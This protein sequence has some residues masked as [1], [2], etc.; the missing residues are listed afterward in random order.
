LHLKFNRILHNVIRLS[1]L[2]VFSNLISTAEIFHPLFI[3]SKVVIVG[4]VVSSWDSGLISSWDTTLR[5][6]YYQNVMHYMFFFYKH[7]K[8][9]NQAWLCLT[10]FDFEAHSMLSL[11]LTFQGTELPVWE[12]FNSNM[13]AKCEYI[14][15]DF[16]DL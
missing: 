2:C 16:Y 14:F 9:Q 12:N 11:C 7:M 5:Y 6:A 15:S 8:F 3:T 1:L 10:V 13:A 4:E